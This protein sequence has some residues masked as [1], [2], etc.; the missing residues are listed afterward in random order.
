MKDQPERC[1]A[2]ARYDPIEPTVD[3]RLVL[4]HA[5]ARAYAEPQTRKVRA[6]G[7]APGGEFP[8]LDG[9][10][11]V[12]DC[13]TV[14]HSLTFGAFEIFEGRRLKTRAVFYQDDLPLT[15]AEGFDRLKQICRALDVKLVKR[16]WLFQ[17][18]IWPAC[19]HGWTVAGFNVAYDL[20]R[21]ADSFEAATKTARLGAR[22]CNGFELNK[23]F[24]GSK[25]H[26]SRAF[27]RIKR[28]DRHHVR[29]DMRRAAVL[30]LATAA[31]A[32]TDKN[33]ALMA[34]APKQSACRAFNVPF[35]TRPGAHSGEITVENVEGCLY[36]VR[37]TSELLWAI[38]A[39]H[40][41]H[42][43]ALHLSRAQSGATI[44]KAYLEALGV[45]P[46]LQVQ[47]DFPKAY[48]GYA[49]QGYYGGRVEA[50]IV[51]T[52]LPC[53]Y[54]DFLSMYPTV[55]ALLGLWL[56][57]V[58]AATLE[59]E[60]I[61]PAEIEALLARLRENP[62]ALFEPETWTLLDFFALVEP[63]GAKLPAR[64][65]I[66]LTSTR[67]RDEANRPVAP[68]GE[69]QAASSAVVTIGP[70]ESVAP[71]WYAGPDL[72]SAAIAGGKPSIVRAWRLRSHGVQE[73]LRPIRFRGDDL[74]DP[75]SDD[76]FAR[77]IELRKAVT[78]DPI[79]DERRST[80]YKVVANSGAYGV[81]AETTPMDIDPD[82]ENRKARR[83]T[84][85]ADS[86]FET[87]VD[88]PER[89]GRFNFFPTA[90]LVTAGARLM[91]ALAQREVE[92]LGGEVAYCDTD[93]LM[94]VSTRDGGFVPCEGGLYR[95]DDG[96]RAVRALSFQEVEAVRERFVS[97]NPYD[98]AIVPGSVLKL[99]DENF[100]DEVREA[101]CELWCYA[102]SEK[103]YALF[104]IDA[105]GEP[106]IR[107]YSSHVLGQYRSPDPGVD[108]HAWIIDAWKREVSAAFGK[109]IEPF[110]WERYP[111]I[112]QLT[113][114][115]WSVFKPYR[116]NQRLHPFDFLAVGVLNRSA[117]D[118]AIE[119][120]EALERCCEE[121]RPACALFLDLAEWREQHWQCLR[122]ATPWDFESRP[123][124]KTYG[125]LIRSTLQGVERKRLCADGSVPT[126]RTRGL[127]IPRP[128]RVES[129]TAI[130]KE[131]VVDP[132]DTDEGLTAEMLSATEVLEYE[133]LSERLDALRAKV[134]VGGV[135]PIARASGVSRSKVQAFVNQG[136][137]PHESTLLR[138]ER[139]VERHSA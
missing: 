59:V 101:R 121:P 89:P 126:R 22:F 139:V 77:L 4:R 41:R 137:T 7:H 49:A 32:Y 123:R 3:D 68:N 6:R 57:H 8:S 50:R 70:V 29:F 96:S 71:L 36:D 118:L 26:I 135:K 40:S 95:L 28:D 51:K 134:R 16:E 39:E 2:G 38:D 10:V 124:L 63:N 116:E 1:Q 100:A 125:S 98:R 23:R 105:R 33:L 75:R 80:G 74:I 97:L 24:V 54:L 104:T 129:K 17:N 45:T 90:S 66:T 102:V 52:L 9:T 120:V 78:P 53:A 46:R 128:V 21:I 131:V 62:D 91:L 48:L 119:E 106:G 92:R 87:E 25:S 60:E 31:F 81:F 73:T 115:T 99:E 56:K 47:P 20:S 127:L 13:E 85:Y 79:D 112:A 84:V 113:L 117:I 14:E 67:A 138:L 11:L 58:A 15:N 18:A 27:C 65:P 37:K 110:A 83:V 30:D 34:E 132:T 19:K 88:R 42:P 94:V 12:F 130:G 93:G 103:L 136:A 122:C 69:R 43:I 108:C 55:F 44:A 35:E 76:F 64:A 61:A 133:D 114:T 72:A 111:A 82:E 86:T 5:F 107:K 109:P